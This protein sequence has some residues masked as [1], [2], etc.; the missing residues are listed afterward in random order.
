V[1]H[2]LIHCLKYYQDRQRLIAQVETNEIIFEYSNI[3]QRTAEK[4]FHFFVFVFKKYR[5]FEKKL[6]LWKIYISCYTLQSSGGGN[7]IN[8]C[9]P[10]FKN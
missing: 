10:P 4:I 9:Q 3:L 6:I 2:V 8:C 7:A 1:E 5:A